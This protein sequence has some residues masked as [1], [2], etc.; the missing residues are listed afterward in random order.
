MILAMRIIQDMNLA[1]KVMSNVGEWMYANGLSTSEW[2]DPKNM[3]RNFM[4]KHA[5]EE[6]FYVLEISNLPAASV[7]LQDNQRNLSWEPIDGNEKVDALYVHWL[8]VHRDFAGQ[9]LSSKL[10]DFSL[11]KADEIGFD[12]VRLDTSADNPNLMN[13]YKSYGFKVR[14]IE[15]YGNDH[16]I[17][18]FEYM[19]DKS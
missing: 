4:L 5:D 18:Y 19:L 8:A 16:K 3:N 2:W 17:A 12:R 7:V 14:G 10:L 9:G 6:D 13:L 11:M 15:P 1:L